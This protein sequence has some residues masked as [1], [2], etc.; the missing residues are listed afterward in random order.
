MFR[1][2]EAPKPCRR[3][4]TRCS[5]SKLSLQRSI[6]SGQVVP[7]LFRTVVHKQVLS[8][9]EIT[10]PWA[11]EHRLIRLNY[12]KFKVVRMPYVSFTLNSM[13]PNAQ[14]RVLVQSGGLGG[15]VFG[16]RFPRCPRAWGIVGMWVLSGLVV[17]F[18]WRCGA[19][20]DRRLMD[21]IT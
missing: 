2:F 1:C 13:F 16:A 15:T 10:E 14:R 3:P 18:A 8:T 20:D 9:V 4:T 5:R 7:Q 17:H 19:P 21:F 6:C 11:G 12:F